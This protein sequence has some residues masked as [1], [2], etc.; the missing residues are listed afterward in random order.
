MTPIRINDHNQAGF[1]AEYLSAEQCDK[2]QSYSLEILMRTGVRLFHPEAVDMLKKAGAFVSEGNRVRIP[3]DLVEK[4]FTTV[5]K[6]VTLYDRHGKP[7][8]FAEDYLC[9]YGTG[10]DCLHIVDHRTGVRRDPVLNDIIEGM[11]V[12]DALPNIDFVMSMF[13]PVDVDPLV[14]DRYQ[15]EAMLN[16]TTKP[17]VFVTN[18]FSGAVDAVEMAEIAVGGVETL[19]QRPNIACYINV[20]TGLRHNEEALQKLLFLAEKGLPAMYIPVVMGGTTGPITQP[21]SVAL[22]YAGVLAGLVLSQLK[23]EGAPCIFPGWGGAPIDMRTLISPY[24]TPNWGSIAAALAH[25]Y[26]MPMFGLAGCSDS[27]VVDQQAAAEA[28]LTLLGETLGGPNI[29]HDLG[30]LE[31]GLSGSLA[32]LVI[33]NEIVDWIQSFLAPVVIDDETVPLDLIDAL[34]PDGQYMTT[35]HTLQHYREHWYPTVFDRGNHNQWVAKGGKTLGERAAAQVNKILD[36][37]KIEPL[38]PEKQK[39]IHAIVERAEAQAKQQNR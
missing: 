13:L 18:E 31:S 15:M 10:S 29:I 11:T 2:L 36:S 30:Y 4:A 1:R 19:R 24:C 35:D 16:S 37:H 7:A 3:A 28:A 6:Q 5:P 33:C 21:G 23:S 12:C 25:S 22:V 39:A 9:Y 8:I 34:G 27:K 32:Q 14:S 20:T 17:I 38:P 26:R